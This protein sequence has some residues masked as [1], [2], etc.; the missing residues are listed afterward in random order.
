MT[1]NTQHTH[2]TVIPVFNSF[3]VAKHQRSVNMETGI[4][5]RIIAFVRDYF[6]EEGSI[7]REYLAARDAYFATFSK[8][9]KNGKQTEDACRVFYTAFE[10]RVSYLAEILHQNQVDEFISKGLDGCN[11]AILCYNQNHEHA[12]INALPWSSFNK[13]ITTAIQDKETS[14]RTQQSSINTLSGEITRLKQQRLAEREKWNDAAYDYM[15]TCTSAE[16]EPS[17]SDATRETDSIDNQLIEREET[18][19]SQLQPRLAKCK[20]EIE[21][22]YRLQQILTEWSKATGYLLHE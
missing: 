8:Y 6:S 22:L 4:I 20:R 18:Y 11:A 9:G 10:K 13:C 3:E 17:M 2:Q 5:G 21:M 16:A 7:V 19:Q 1:T 12:P 15:F 14:K